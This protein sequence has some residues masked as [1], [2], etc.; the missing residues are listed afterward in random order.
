MKKETQLL[1]FL[2]FILSI[3]NWL[4]YEVKLT[5]SYDFNIGW[6]ID[7]QNI[8]KHHQ[9]AY[10]SLLLTTRKATLTKYLWTGNKMANGEY[11]YIGACASSDRTI[12]FGTVIKWQGGECVV[13]DRTALW[14]FNK[15]GLT[16]DLYTEESE[17]QAL[18]FGR[19]TVDV[20]Y[21]Q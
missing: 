20:S 11:P 8:N 16:I 6:Y 4:V 18:Q 12:P 13:K 14:V 1:L 2:V 17:K 15:F 21:T 5:N 3:A 10:N 7:T 9:Q 19:R